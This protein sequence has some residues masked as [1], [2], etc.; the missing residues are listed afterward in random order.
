MLDTLGTEGLLGVGLIVLAIALLTWYDP[1]VGAGVMI[2]VAGFAL[3]ARGVAD[4]V[5]QLFG[6]K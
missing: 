4:S 1:I 5:M 3:V 2:L 6:M